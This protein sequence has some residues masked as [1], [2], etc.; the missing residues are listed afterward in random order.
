LSTAATIT[1]FD[2]LKLL[3][4]R[5]AAFA[6]G[7]TEDRYALWLGSAISFDRLP[8]LKQLIETVLEHLRS[9]I[10]PLDTN[11][12]Y[13]AALESALVVAG[14]TTAERTSCD[15]GIPFVDWPHADT[16]AQRL[17]NQYS[18]LLQVEV[19][20]EEDDYLLWEGVGV[21]AT[22]AD[23]GK[24]PDVEHLCIAILLLEGVFSEI[25]SANWDGLIE[26]AV[27]ELA[28]NHAT[29]TVFIRP[30]DF[31][32]PDGKA[33]LYKF[34]GCAVKAG[35]N[36]PEYRPYFTG[37]QA[38]INRWAQNNPAMAD[39]LQHLIVSRP[40]LM[41]GLSAQDPNIQNIFARAEASVHW[42]WPGDRPSYVFSTNSLGVDQK[43]LLQIVYRQSMTAANR[44]DIADSAAFPAYA[45]PLLLGLTLHVLSQ[46]LEKLIE[47]AHLPPF[48]AADRE[49]LREGITACRD[50]IAHGIG[51]DRFSFL[52]DFIALSCKALGMFRGGQVPGLLS[53]YLP[54]TGSVPQHFHGDTALLTSGLTEAAIAVA[55]IGLLVKDGK[56]R[57]T[58]ADPGVFGSGAVG[59]EST[60]GAAKVFFTANSNVALRLQVNGL[61][62]DSSDTVVVHSLEIVTPLARSPRV[63]PGRTGR[64]GRRETS[65]S[66]ILAQATSVPELVQL[67]RMEIGL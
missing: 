66:A 4:G 18:R 37:S 30:K 3:D 26:K 21:V 57:V 17:I 27:E 41:V 46:K 9:R 47:L 28:E 25:A 6:Q 62:T 44:T 32:Q 10:D 33:N 40:T 54:L 55:I 20:G 45:K 59:F 11:C 49:L 8:G 16:L 31:Q 67:F 50:Q 48:S 22:F 63:P 36:E 38:Q 14:I 24:T 2:T 29:L 42:P 7:V 23:P 15:F 35:A 65:I 19:T 12:K 56:L 39:R 64:A 60:V 52:K 1:V 13:Q 53:R 5:F 61:V 58:R 43:S 34:H 51:T